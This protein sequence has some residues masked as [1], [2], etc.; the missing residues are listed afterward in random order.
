MRGR[1]SCG[2]AGRPGQEV[3]SKKKGLG[4]LFIV[5]YHMCLCARERER[6]EREKR[7][8]GGD[9]ERKGENRRGRKQEREE[10]KA[11]RRDSGRG[12]EAEGEKNRSSQPSSPFAERRTHVG[13]LWL[14]VPL[15]VRL[16]PLG[17]S[18]PYV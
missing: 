6:V 11:R 15:G 18:S 8:E 14:A 1:L 16:P 9:S 17:N 10:K 12:P 13:R 3:L 4:M 7:G 2:R 5:V